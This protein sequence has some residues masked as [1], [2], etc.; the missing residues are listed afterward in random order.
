[1]TQLVLGRAQIKPSGSL[2]LGP[3]LLLSV[4]TA[5]LIGEDCQLYSFEC[6]RP[7]LLVTTPPSLPLTSL[8]K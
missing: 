3:E 8:A 5:S 6:L 7:S 4:H 2:T 1:M